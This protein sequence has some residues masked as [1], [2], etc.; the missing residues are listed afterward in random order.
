MS[1]HHTITH[2][3]IAEAAR[4]AGVPEH[5]VRR[6]SLGLPP[7][8]SDREAIMRALAAVGADTFVA[9]ALSLAKRPIRPDDRAEIEK[10]NQEKIR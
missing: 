4:R 6:V 5:D 1:I 7:L 9:R 2:E 8:R 10:P 3:K